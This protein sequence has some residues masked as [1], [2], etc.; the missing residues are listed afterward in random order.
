MTTPKYPWS[1]FFFSVML[2]FNAFVVFLPWHDAKNILW[3][4]GPALCGGLIGFLL[5]FVCSSINDFIRKYQEFSTKEFHYHIDGVGYF[6][7]SNYKLRGG[8]KMD[9][10][11]PLSGKCIKKAQTV[12]VEYHRHYLRERFGILSFIFDFLYSRQ[13]TFY[14]ESSDTSKGK[15]RLR[16]I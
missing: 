2:T 3:Y 16:L 14:A 7:S 5:Y 10:K 8:V 1:V 13:V 4:L 6:H 11:L 12:V 9:L 15:Y